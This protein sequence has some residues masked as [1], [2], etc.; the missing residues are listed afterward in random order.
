[1]QEPLAWSCFT[2]LEWLLKGFGIARI[3]YGH[4]DGGGMCVGDVF[5]TLAD[6]TKISQK[7]G[8]KPLVNFE[9]GL[10]KTV[11]YFKKSFNK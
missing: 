3:A 10:V 11:A 4:H 8:F 2:C 6:I 9:D 7:I 1:L 5:R